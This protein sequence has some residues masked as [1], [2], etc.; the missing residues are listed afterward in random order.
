MERSRGPFTTEQV[1][2]AL[3]AL[4]EFMEA[5]LVVLD[6][7]SD[8]EVDLRFMERDGYIHGELDGDRDDIAL[9]IGKRGQTLDAIQYV[10]NA[11]AMSQCD[12]LIPVR[13]DAQGYRERRAG[14]LEKL[15]DRAVENVR[16]TGREVELEPMTSSERK[17]VHL[18]LKDHPD[19]STE[20]TGKDPHRRVVVEP[21]RD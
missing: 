9:I 6:V 10:A 14:Q 20:S 12:A 19:V 21:R 16:D 7:G 18:Y 13:I 5:T 17:V 2:E 15:A 8:L 3:D 4:A 11:V 1:D